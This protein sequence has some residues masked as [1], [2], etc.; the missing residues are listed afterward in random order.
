MKL[1]MKTSLRHTYAKHNCNIDPYAYAFY[2]NY[3]FESFTA[4]VPCVFV[5]IEKN[6]QK[7]KS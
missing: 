7:K 4:S 3:L 6:F 2:K 1:V 5:F